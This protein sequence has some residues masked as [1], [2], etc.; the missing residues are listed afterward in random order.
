MKHLSVGTAKLAIPVPDDF[1]PYR[2]WGPRCLTGIHDDL[3]VR[4][5]F[6]K[7]SQPLLF[8]VVE[9]GD[10]D[11]AWS[12]R[13][14]AEVDLTVDQVFIS[15]THTHTAPYIGSYW[16][17][18]VRDV[19]K[20]EQYTI[21][22]WN[23]V[24]TAAKQAMA[25]TN[26]ATVQFS[27]GSCNVNVN[28]DVPNVDPFTGKVGYSTGQNFHGPSDKRVHVICFSGEDGNP[29]AVLFNYAVH[30]SVLFGTDQKDGGQ[31]ISGD[32]AGHAMQYVETVL[33]HNCVA[34][35]AMAPAANQDPRYSG[36]Y[37]YFD[38]IGHMQRKD[39]GLGSYALADSL[40]RELAAEVTAISNSGTPLH[41]TIAAK[42]DTVW[43]PGKVKKE[44]PGMSP[45]FSPEDFE[46]AEP[47]PVPIGAVRLGN[48]LIVTIGCEITSHI[49]EEIETALASVGF[50][51]IFV[52]T[53]CNGS[54]SY[55]ADDDGYA[56]VTFT[57]KASHM[58][59][60]A[61]GY[62][63]NAITKIAAALH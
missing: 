33:G 1:F 37:M 17:E 38:S 9:T 40:G 29:I 61:S 11:P 6:L 13:L 22:A 45:P 10:I 48:V 24:V 23:T 3:F 21:S 52:I 19:E 4:A 49:G 16:P 15:A 62:L 7:T 56:K 55:M 8:I 50:D 41:G 34:M 60:G 54:S 46:P 28:R 53:Q 5:L 36:A 47:V 14:A 18:N 32:L 25:K 30:S 35:F 27:V 59:P 58:M 20:S 26:P 51:H 39:F 31:L 63:T 42:T 57:A 43:T 44:G 12:S 2:A